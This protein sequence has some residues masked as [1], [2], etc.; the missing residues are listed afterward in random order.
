M[1][2]E[3]AQEKKTKN[4][5]FIHVELEQWSKRSDDDSRKIRVNFQ[6]ERNL[7]P[8]INHFSVNEVAWKLWGDILSWLSKRQ[9][10][11]INRF[12]YLQVHSQNKHVDLSSS[13]SKAVYFNYCSYKVTKQL[14]MKT[15]K[16]FYEG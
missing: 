12:K 15:E 5:C 1:V 8:K 16:C 13:G 14:Q 6:S 9:W 11:I 10:Y 3:R 2:S 4:D 7:R